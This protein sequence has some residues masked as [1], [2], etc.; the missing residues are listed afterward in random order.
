MHSKY[1]AALSK[2]A[3]TSSNNGNKLLEGYSWKEGF[4]SAIQKLSLAE[5]AADVQVHGMELRCRERERRH[6]GSFLR[7]AIRGLEQPLSNTQDD[8]SV[9]EGPMNTKSS[10]FICGPPG[11]GK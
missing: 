9:D 10:I 5:A 3:S 8:D 6:I 2:L 1:K 11:T 4:Q 7:K